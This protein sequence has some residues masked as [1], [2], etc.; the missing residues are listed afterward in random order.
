LLGWGGEWEE[1]GKKLVGQ[2]EGSL[3]EQQTKQTVTIKILIRKIYKTAECT[4]QLSPPNAQHSPKLRLTS[5]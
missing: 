2:D 4:E 5:P 1:A 3:T